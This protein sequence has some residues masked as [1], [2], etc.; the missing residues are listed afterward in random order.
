MSTDLK[1][2]R[3][4]LT[5]QHPCSY[6]QNQQERVAVALDDELHN[7]QNYQILLANGFRRSGNTIY[8][9]HCEHC[10]ACQPIRIAIQDFT[11]TKSQKRLI[12]KAKHLHWEMKPQ[13]DDD[14]FD[15][16]SRYICQR[17]KNGTMYPPKRDDFARFAQT[18]W[19]TTQYLHGYTEAGQ[20]VA[21]AVTDCM[22]LCSSA[23][24][25]FYDP[26]LPI[27]LGTLAV[28]EQIKNCRINQQQWLYLGYQIDECPAM[29]Y[30][31]RFQRHQRLVNQRWQG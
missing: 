15:L 24:Y 16:Y 12:N 10:S 20:L 17:H 28:L 23:F 2:I 13:M 5:N 7:S 29:N 31:T 18:D 22:D 14:W 19:L 3:I 26:D 30:K 8:K 9:P 25:T 11:P 1:H 6:L 27:S 21:V 4:G